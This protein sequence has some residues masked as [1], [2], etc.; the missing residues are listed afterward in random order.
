MTKEIPMAHDA[1]GNAHPYDL[2]ERTARFGEA[3]IAFAK[4]KEA[5]ELHL[6]FCSIRNQSRD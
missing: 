4:R 6:I 3:V 5:K 2:E 1:N